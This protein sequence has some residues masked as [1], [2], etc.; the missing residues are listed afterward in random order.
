MSEEK[1]KAHRDGPS[2]E[3]WPEV[4]DC[5]QAKAW[6]SYVVDIKDADW[7]PK[8]WPDV[9]RADVDRGWERAYFYHK[10]DHAFAKMIEG[11][12]HHVSQWDLTEQNVHAELLI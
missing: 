8:R 3:F 5:V 1:A 6:R 4:L 9:V 2:S 11:T 12:D 10:D 7:D